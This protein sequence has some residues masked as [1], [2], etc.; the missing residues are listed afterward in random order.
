[1]SGL[2]TDIQ[3]ELRKIVEIQNVLYGP[4]SI[5]VARVLLPIAE[6]YLRQ[7][8]YDL[9]ERYANKSLA[10]AKLRT[11]A[12]MPLPARG[13]TGPREPADHCYHQ[14]LLLVGTLAVRAGPVHR[15]QEHL[16]S[17]VRYEQEYGL[18]RGR[19]FSRRL[20]LAGGGGARRP[21]SGADP[22][23][24]GARRDAERSPAY[25]GRSDAGDALSGCRKL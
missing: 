16:V 4:T 15:G 24:L 13:R 1:M 5:E 7:G 19:R 6:E 9:A 17:A 18:G 11:A 12:L 8:Q 25:A 22:L 10:I 2:A 21:A 20:S 3:Q 23:W 14:A